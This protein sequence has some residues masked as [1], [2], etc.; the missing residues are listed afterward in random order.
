MGDSCGLERLGCPPFAFPPPSMAVARIREQL[1]FVRTVA[2]AAADA[3]RGREGFML[4]Q[5]G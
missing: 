2:G 3:A 4:M 5:E 1:G